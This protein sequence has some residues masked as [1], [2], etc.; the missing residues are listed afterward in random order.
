MD[1]RKYFR[2]QLKACSFFRFDINTVEREKARER[3][4]EREKERERKRER[5]KEL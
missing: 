3:D 5:E 4:I 2:L 1:T